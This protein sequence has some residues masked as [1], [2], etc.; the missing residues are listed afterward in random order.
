MPFILAELISEIRD[1]L[2]CVSVT[3]VPDS[4]I[5]N[6]ID[7]ALCKYSA[8]H[9]LIEDIQVTVDTDGLVAA[10]ADVLM[11]IAD[12]WSSR[13]TEGIDI[14]NLLGFES[15]RDFV[16]T[17]SGYGTND[18]RELSVDAYLNEIEAERAARN[19]PAH[20]RLVGATY[21]FLP[22]PTEQRTAYLRVG[23]KH[24]ATTFPDRHIEYLRQGAFARSLR[25][26]ALRRHKFNSIN[27][28]GEKL[29]FRDTTSLMKLSIEMWREFIK[30]LGPMRHTQV[31]SS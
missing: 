19:L 3:E 14:D 30:S 16:A 22:S 25:A 8:H 27:V 4:T 1:D 7:S 28:G 10:A 29:A 24:T 9:P 15:T 17:F 20:V 23:K 12:S 26:L 13:V 5:A 2:G 11:I 21:E 31:V 18:L 6:A